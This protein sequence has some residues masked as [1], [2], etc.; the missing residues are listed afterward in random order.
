[1]FGRKSAVVEQRE[2]DDAARARLLAKTKSLP[3]TP[4]FKMCPKCGSPDLGRAY[5]EQILEDPYRSGATPFDCPHFGHPE[6]YERLDVTC[7]NCLYHVG[8]EQPKELG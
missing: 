1:M 6:Q 8:K 7:H 4:Y 5:R 2:S 3:L